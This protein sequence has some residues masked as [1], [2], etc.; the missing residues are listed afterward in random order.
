MGTM[1]SY[2][3]LAVVEVPRKINKVGKM[4]GIGPVTT[5]GLR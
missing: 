5:F 1:T 3:V 4:E 2:I